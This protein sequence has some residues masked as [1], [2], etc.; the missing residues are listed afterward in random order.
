MSS[1][2]REDLNLYDFAKKYQENQSS[3][4][5]VKKQNATEDKVLSARLEYLNNQKILTMKTLEKEIDLIKKRKKYGWDNPKKDSLS[6]HHF[7]RAS[8]PN[9]PRRWTKDNFSPAKF[10]KRKFLAQSLPYRDKDAIYPSE[11]VCET[12]NELPYKQEN[13]RAEKLLYHE[14]HHKHHV[15][16]DVE[17]VNIATNGMESKETLAMPDSLNHNNSL[18]NL[19]IKKTKAMSASD[20]NAVQNAQ[21]FPNNTL[22]RKGI[23]P[24]DAIPVAGGN[25][26]DKMINPSK[27]FPSWSRYH[28][29]LP[30][31]PRQNPGEEEKDCIKGSSVNLNLRKIPSKSNHTDSIKLKSDLCGADFNPLLDLGGGLK[32]VRFKNLESVLIPH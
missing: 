17:T 24:G 14:L 5:L 1:Q 19:C 21:S 20:E 31:D 25:S 23:F 22:F 27:A 15:D 13:K 16:N 32:D 6:S 30:H 7:D 11:N 4:E 3:S 9:T 12:N 28:P 2:R 8:L 29:R 18:S 26:R 10:V